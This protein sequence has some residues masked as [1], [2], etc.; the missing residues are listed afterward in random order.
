[1]KTKRSILLTGITVLAICVAATSCQK[2]RDS[3]NASNPGTN[4]GSLTGGNAKVSYPHTNEFKSTNMHGHTFTSD[5]KSCRTCHGQDLS[6]G[7]AKVACSKCHAD[8]PHSKEF[9][10][11]TAHGASY[12]KNPGDCR[13]CHGQDLAGG[14]VKVACS[15]C[16]ADFPHDKDFTTTTAHGASYFN[17]PH[18][19]KTCHNFASDSKDNQQPGKACNTCHNYPHINQWAMPDKHGA[20]FLKESKALPDQGPAASCLH[21]H[22]EKSTFKERHP[23]R[24][25]S[26]GTCHILL[27]HSK[28]FKEGLG[29]HAKKARSYVG[30]CTNCHSDLKR[31]MP[32]YAPDGGCTACHDSNQI[33]VVSWQDKESISKLKGK[34]RK[35]ASQPAKHKK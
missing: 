21:C 13:T 32:N 17:N 23:D 12:L 22:G 14:D 24:I 15:K 5:E 28:T 16:H 11:T 25:Y 30:G 35:F 3:Q 7:N 9:T 26:C 33:P 18:N 20:A 6:G 2:Q 31:L 27:P 1:M 4:T 8:F 34:T 10:T 29:E 19:C